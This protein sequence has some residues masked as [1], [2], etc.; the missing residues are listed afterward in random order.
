MKYETEITERLR[1]AI[2]EAVKGEMQLGW[3]LSQLLPMLH[4]AVEDAVDELE[5]EY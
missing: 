2:V 3:S 4:N 5:K 1:D